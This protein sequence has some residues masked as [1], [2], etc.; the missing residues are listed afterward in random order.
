MRIIIKFKVN[1]L[2]KI[3]IPVN[4]TLR[5]R[6]NNIVEVYKQVKKIPNHKTLINTSLNKFNLKI[7]KS[8]HNLTNQTK[9]SKIKVLMKNMKITKIGINSR[10]ST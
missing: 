9:S 3:T 5:K 8:I 2:L 4:I 6:D 7:S 10:I 1:K